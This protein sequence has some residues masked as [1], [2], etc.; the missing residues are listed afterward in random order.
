MDPGPAIHLAHPPHG[1]H[2]TLQCASIARSMTRGW[3]RRKFFP[4]DKTL[5]LPRWLHL[6]RRLDPGPARAHYRRAA[7]RGNRSKSRLV[8][9]Q[10]ADGRPDPAGPPGPPIVPDRSTRT[11]RQ[12]HVGPPSCAMIEPSASS[13]IEWTI[14][15]GWMTT[16]IVRKIEQPVRLDHLE[17]FV[18]QRGRID[19]DLAAHPPRRMAQR[20][21]RR[22]AFERRGR[23]LAKRPARRRQDD[24]SHLL[25]P[26][27]VQT[28]M[29]GVVLAVDRQ[30]A[31]PRARAAA[32]TSA[33]AITSTSLLAS[34]IVLPAS[35]AASTASSAAVPDDAQMT[36]STS[37][38]VATAMSPRCPLS[39]ASAVTSTSKAAACSRSRSAFDPAARPTT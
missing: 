27:A 2:G 14:D 11:D 10:A 18:H 8:K 31:T 22:D 15:C 30:N 16:S 4:P 25:A 28:L 26:P 3:L 5:P 6:G 29:D 12:F 35:I 32:V 13:T 19:G 38:C 21:L 9:V 1:G 7:D 34:A 24:A 33:P 36:M 17:A 37:G 23:H 20:V 39:D